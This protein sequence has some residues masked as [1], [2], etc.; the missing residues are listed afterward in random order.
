MWLSGDGPSMHTAPQ[1][2][3]P[4]WAQ[5]MPAIPALR[6][7]RQD[8]H[9]FQTSLDHIVRACLKNTTFTSEQTEKETMT[10]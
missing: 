2:K 10:A 6:K 3:N 7:L 9:K 4:T 8:C 5:S 1:A